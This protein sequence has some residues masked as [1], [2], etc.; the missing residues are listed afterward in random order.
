MIA[1][2][3]NPFSQ[4]RVRAW[5]AT[6]PQHVMTLV[7]YLPRRA[8]CENA[9]TFMDRNRRD[10]AKDMLH[11]Y[12]YSM[13][14][15]WNAFR[16]GTEP[17][18]YWQ[19]D[20]IRP[21]H[22]LVLECDYAPGTDELAGWYIKYYENKTPDPPPKAKKRTHS[23]RGEGDDDD[24]I[25]SAA[26]PDPEES[27]QESFNRQARE[28]VAILDKACLGPNKRQWATKLPS[29]E[30]WKAACMGAARM[31][32][33]PGDEKCMWD[34]IGMPSNG[35]LMQVIA[36]HALLNANRENDVESKD[37][38]VPDATANGV[39]SVHSVYGIDVAVSIKRRITG[40]ALRADGALMTHSEEVEKHMHHGL[41]VPRNLND[42][43]PAGRDAVKLDASF[44]SILDG[45][46][47]IQIPD[48][49]A[50]LALLHT[51]ESQLVLQHASLSDRAIQRHL[52]RMD[53]HGDRYS[54]NTYVNMMHN[55]MGRYVN[56]PEHATRAQDACISFRR[57]WDSSTPGMA[58]C[59]STVADL[60][61]D[62]ASSGKLLST[63][64][65]PKDMTC[66]QA[67][68]S[69]PVFHYLQQVS[70]QA[71]EVCNTRYTYPAM[72]QLIALLDTHRY[73]PGSA[74][75]RQCLI[76]IAPSQSGKSYG[77]ML[78]LSFLPDGVNET[79]ITASAQAFTGNEN[80]Q[81]KVM[82][83]EEI[84]GDHFGIMPNYTDRDIFEWTRKVDGSAPET[85]SIA[86]AITKARLTNATAGTRMLNTTNGSREV[87]MTD[88]VQYYTM[89]CATNESIWAFPGTF[90]N[91]SSRIFCVDTDVQ[92]NILNKVKNDAAKA[93]FKEQ[94]QDLF[95]F[96]S[97]L[98]IL[99]NVNILPDM[100][101]SA[102]RDFMA[103]YSEK[104]RNESPILANNLLARET[105]NIWAICRVLVLMRIALMY[106][107]AG[108]GKDPDGK[109]NLALLVRHARPLMTLPLNYM[110]F[111]IEFNE[112]T[113]MSIVT[114]VVT[115]LR[116]EVLGLNYNENNGDVFMSPDDEQN[117]R[118]RLEGNYFV[119]TH[120]EFAADGVPFSVSGRGGGGGAQQ[121]QGDEN[122][123]E[124]ETITF[125]KLDKLAGILHRYLK[126]YTQR[127]IL[128][129]LCRLTT[130]TT[131]NC[132]PGY[133]VHRPGITS[134]V[135][136][137]QLRK[138]G[139]IA[140]H[141]RA[142]WQFHRDFAYYT[143]LRCLAAGTKLAPG[144]R[145]IMRKDRPFQFEHAQWEN[146]SRRILSARDRQIQRE[147]QEVERQLTEVQREVDD[148][149]RKRADPDLPPVP[150]RRFRQH[151][152]QE[153]KYIL[154]RQIM[155]CED[156]IE[157]LQRQEHALRG[158][159]TLAEY[160]EAMFNAAEA[161]AAASD[162]DDDAPVA[163]LNALSLRPSQQVQVQQQQ[164][165]GN[166]NAAIGHSSRDYLEMTGI[167]DSH[168]TL[169]TDRRKRSDEETKM[170][171]DGDWSAIE[172]LH[173]KTHL[174]TSRPE[175]HFISHIGS[176]YNA[177]YDVLVSACKV[178]QAIQRIDVNRPDDAKEM[179]QAT[180]FS[181]C[182]SDFTQILATYGNT[183]AATPFRLTASMVQQIWNIQL[184]DVL[185]CPPIA[186]AVE[187]MVTQPH[188]AS[189]TE[190][191][192]IG[193][194]RSNISKACYRLHERMAQ[195]AHEIDDLRQ[196]HVPNHNIEL[197]GADELYRLRELDSPSVCPKP[198]SDKFKAVMKILLGHVQA[199]NIYDIPLHAMG[200]HQL[201]CYIRYQAVRMHPSAQAGIDAVTL[202]RL[203][204]YKR[205]GHGQAFANLLSQIETQNQHIQGTVFQAVGVPERPLRAGAGRRTPPA[206]SQSSRGE[207]MPPLLIPPSPELFNHANAIE[208]QD[209]APPS[210]RGGEEGR[211]RPP[212]PPQQQQAPSRSSTT[213][214]SSSRSFRMGDD[215]AEEVS[216]S[217]A[218]REDAQAGLSEMEEDA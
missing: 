167:A 46:S 205:I 125:K 149:R 45:L 80:E 175:A 168:T 157:R 106:I 113:Y 191:P 123:V 1:D 24:D 181:Q 214:S 42:G 84:Q 14:L 18:L 82:G 3:N 156:R 189:L 200:I 199:R 4:D 128:G 164:P 215:E 74:A 124:R 12:R 122:S 86:Y 190:R 5:V 78:I 97:L 136:A 174:G 194:R 142:Q 193:N 88:A 179:K 183:L 48:V 207:L 217:E 71:H 131:H 151:G 107:T 11:L 204:N 34:L 206:L 152:L 166:N 212:P 129:T 23:A 83:R 27:A 159:Q 110:T 154:D 163:S 22:F 184:A 130:A 16:R 59:M 111:A 208:M 211:L 105:E 38:S 165:R 162:D 187:I 43:Q 150:N 54:W 203:F 57:H 65:L 31:L 173:L 117:R 33:F 76:M 112:F 171:A 89:L 160:E 185:F 126:G 116:R 7:A 192:S 30:W 115:T 90:T 144:L 26:I 210:P 145:G 49:R 195:L 137:L 143:I 147:L 17:V 47:R 109:L 178:K 180:Y 51:Y 8:L 161:A 132:A 64:G 141:I 103:V 19:E 201:L 63:I 146:K 213:S 85:N 77:L 121:Q 218:V 169:G 197:N 87:T 133:D 72:R 28:R 2:H 53:T 100:D 196:N 216:D 29:D 15:F 21:N 41:V 182:L 39:L 9:V 135:P 108:L 6:H 79:I 170:L 55:M 209:S 202:A 36:V 148:A 58:R 98:Q 119:V 186:L 139:G 50:R 172:Q 177:Y 104:I 73:H 68:T 155:N 94:F 92:Q 138:D 127:D 40:P 176:I 44:S 153:A 37:V 69:D 140:F 25:K 61:W 95:V 114:D 118:V 188:H 70:M 60:L 20:L 35:E 10:D 66:H 96:V 120:P 67:D 198:I 91:R 93:R 101:T 13:M 81:G 134:I 52:A 56:G 32:D 75:P 62:R 158:G 102:A 99:I